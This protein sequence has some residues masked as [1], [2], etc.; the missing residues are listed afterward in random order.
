MNNT[1]EII[2]SFFKYILR[3]KNEMI[4]INAKTTNKSLITITESIFKLFK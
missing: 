4:R 3:M 1:K 2:V